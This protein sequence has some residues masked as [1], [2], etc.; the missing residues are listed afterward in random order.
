MEARKLIIIAIVLAVAGIATADSWT[1]STHYLRLNQSKPSGNTDNV[2]VMVSYDAWL[3]PNQTFAVEAIGS[4]DN[5]AEIY[6]GG[7]NTKWHMAPWGESDLYGGLYA[8]YVHVTGMPGKTSSGNSRSEDGWIYGP[9]VGLRFPAFTNTELFVEYR[10]G[11]IDGATLPSAFDEANMI[12]FGLEI[13][14]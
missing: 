9:M 3:N 7:F 13:K 4:W 1:I 2:G 11:W 5:P 12:M 6:G 14:F 10:Y 8:D